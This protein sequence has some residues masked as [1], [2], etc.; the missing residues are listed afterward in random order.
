MIQL[1]AL[2]AA[3]VVVAAVAGAL[4]LK[5][6]QARR[7]ALALP[8]GGAGVPYVIYFWGEGCT[9]CRT[10]QEPALSSL[11]GVKVEKVDALADRDLASRF[12]VFT[13]P[14]TVVVGADGKARHVNYGYTPTR[15]LKA[16]LTN[17]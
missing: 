13:L 9:V 5:S 2:L 14:T 8:A 7:A 15:K 17:V 1:Q 6:R 16:Q 12:Q 11:E 10:H 3:A 4:W